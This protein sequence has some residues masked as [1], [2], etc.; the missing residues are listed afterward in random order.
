MICVSLEGKACDVRVPGGREAGADAT[1]EC[2]SGWGR[3]HRYDVEAG[4]VQRKVSEDFPHIAGVEFSGPFAGGG[5]ST[6]W[7]CVVNGDNGGVSGYRFDVEKIREDFFETVVRVNECKRNR[8]DI[9]AGGKELASRQAV[10]LRLRRP[11]RI[12]SS[13]S[14]VRID[15]DGKRGRLGKP[16]RTAMQDSEFEVDSWAKGRVD[17]GKHFVV[18]RT[19]EA[20]GGRAV[21]K[22]G[23]DRIEHRCPSE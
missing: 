9:E 4:A 8:R 16:E 5:T 22:K 17:P 19:G 12:G 2:K 6:K 11:G 18:V 23:F 7:D 13:G 3:A 1:D 10:Q 14:R 20:G 21:V 15:T